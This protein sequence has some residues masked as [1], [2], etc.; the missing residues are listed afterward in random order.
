[1]GF[2]CKSQLIRC[3]PQKGWMD[4]KDERFNLLSVQHRTCSATEPPQIKREHQLWS[5]RKPKPPL[6]PKCNPRI[7]CEC[8]MWPRTQLLWSPFCPLQLGVVGGQFMEMFTHSAQKL[9]L[10]STWRR[11]TMQIWSWGWIYRIK[12]GCRSD[13]SH[14]RVR[15]VSVLRCVCVRRVT[16]LY[17]QQPRK[18]ISDEQT[19]CHG[20]RAASARLSWRGTHRG[21]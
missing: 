12:D 16:E 8:A 2:Y 3:Q 5:E 15:R 18:R 19:A 11:S 10:N 17:T 13:G 7:K 9:R 1:M 6:A 20:N 14:A 21:F 4:F